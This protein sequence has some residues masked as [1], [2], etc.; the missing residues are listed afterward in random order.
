M[1]PLTDFFFLS[2]IGLFAV[3]DLQ[4]LNG[5]LVTVQNVPSVSI[6]LWFLMDFGSI[7]HDD[8]Y[9]YPLLVLDDGRIALYKQGMGLLR[10]YD[11][12]TGTLTTVS[13]M[14][15][16]HSR[17]VGIYTG[18]TVA[19]YLYTVH[20]RGVS[21]CAPGCRVMRGS[22][23]LYT[24]HLHGASRC[25]PGCRAMSSGFFYTLRT[26]VRRR[27]VYRDSRPRGCFR[28]AMTPVVFFSLMQAM[29]QNLY[30]CVWV[31]VGVGWGRECYMPR[32]VLA[33]LR[34]VFLGAA[35]FYKDSMLTS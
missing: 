12:A 23:Y 6:D 4:N 24:A 14:E 9:A 31:G 32:L 13:K 11:P 17:S 21:R 19:F 35:S 29:C 16:E 10:S 34:L 3:P 28:I 26:S 18:S 20:S 15:M 2:L 1:S 30:M 27:G 5:C 22:F 25:A 7:Y 8:L 33:V